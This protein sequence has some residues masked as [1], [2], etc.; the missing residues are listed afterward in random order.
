[1]ELS[2]FGKKMTE[3]S[4]ILTLM[5]DLGKALNDGTNMIMMGGG[6][7][8]HIPA[9]G[10][11]WRSRMHEILDKDDEFERVIGNYDAPQGKKEFIDALVVFFNREYGWNITA[12]NIAITNGSQNSFFFLFN[13]LGGEYDGGVSRKILFPLCPEYIGYV[14][15][16]I[17]HGLFVSRK[18]KIEIIDEHTF[19]YHIDFDDFTIGDDIAAIC[20]SRPTN[21]TGNVITDSELAHLSDMARAKGIPLIIDNAYGHPFPGVLFEPA[22]LHWDKHIILSMSLSKLGL[23]STRT[24]IMI[25]NEEIVAAIA[26]INAIVNL[27]N[28]TIGQAIL[29]PYIRTGEIKNIVRDTIFPFY[30]ARATNIERVIRREL[31]GLPYYLHKIEGAFFVWL[32]FKGLPIT[33]LQLYERLKKKGLLVVPGHYFFDALA[34]QWDHTDECIR[35]NYAM[36]EA[37]TARGI[38]IL[39]EELRM[40]YRMG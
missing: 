21:P 15:Q 35:M 8:A 31:D 26:S 39:G 3:R 16:G 12:A 36:D 40:I 10:S 7:P 25:A 6:N 32:W 9:V 33:C 34:E 14:D 18:P 5:D 29:E 28:G 19:K 11:I 38:A 27:A 4:G 1:M 30:R 37:M 2:K 23:P 17:N 20:I 24:G 13:I 22:T